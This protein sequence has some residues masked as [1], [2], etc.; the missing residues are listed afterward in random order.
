MNAKPKTAAEMNA[1]MSAIGEELAKNG[2]YVDP[3]NAPALRAELEGLK[4]EYA[5]TLRR[6]GE[7][8]GDDT[9]IARRVAAARRQQIA[10]EREARIEKAVADALKREP[11]TP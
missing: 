1:R 2:R 3:P 9:E 7:A 5:E 6:E 4:T 10:D 8:V 11:V